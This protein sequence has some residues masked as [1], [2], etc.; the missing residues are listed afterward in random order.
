MS[1]NQSNALLLSVLKFID[2]WDEYWESSALDGPS[3]HDLD[4][5]LEKVKEIIN[6]NNQ[7]SDSCE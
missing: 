1:E 6:L 7:E 3:K 5:A 2:T 4:V